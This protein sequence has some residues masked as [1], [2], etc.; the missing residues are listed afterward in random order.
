MAGSH[1]DG[2][3]GLRELGR[4]L[5]GW[6]ARRQRVERREREALERRDR[7]RGEQSCRVHF[8]ERGFRLGFQE[9]ISGGFSG[10]T[11]VSGV[12]A[13]WVWGVMDSAGSFFRQS[14]GVGS[15][16]VLSAG[17]SAGV[18]VDGLLPLTQHCSGFHDL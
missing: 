12:D 2:S 10:G 8:V 18:H 3:F 17:Y 16:H 6:E 9:E 1:P 15:R 5:S 13:F 4:F 14:C 11:A 7:R